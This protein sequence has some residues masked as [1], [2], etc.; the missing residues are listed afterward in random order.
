MDIVVH[1]K[2]DQILAVMARHA[3]DIIEDDQILADAP[4][5]WEEEERVRRLGRTT[6][7]DVEFIA[8][9]DR[10]FHAERKQLIRAQSSNGHLVHEGLELLEKPLVFVLLLQ[11]GARLFHR[12]VLR[13]FSPGAPEKDKTRG[14]EAWFAALLV[15]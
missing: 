9:C 13:R 6:S 4:K 3:F 12:T 2:L 14:G 15:I 8:L 7:M 11:I 1:K 10:C 5:R